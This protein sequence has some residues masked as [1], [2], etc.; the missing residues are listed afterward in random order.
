[1]ITQIQVGA[2]AVGNQGSQLYLRKVLSTK[3]YKFK[4][5]K[6]KLKFFKQSNF[7]SLDQW[8]VLDSHL[9]SK[10]YSLRMPTT[11][12][13]KLN[14]TDRQTFAPILLLQFLPLLK[15]SVENRSNQ[16]QYHSTLRSKP[17]L[18][19]DCSD[20][21]VGGEADSLVM[22]DLREKRAR[23]FTSLSASFSD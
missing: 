23:L 12:Q 7:D 8:Q 13:C 9:E 17:K 5:N 18:R 11:N 14:W 19:K 10:H 16:R 21:L 6:K 22:A 20:F 2:L 3:F 4:K 1:M 15:L